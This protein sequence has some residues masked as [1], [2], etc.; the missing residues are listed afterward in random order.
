MKKKIFK[1][2]GIIIILWILVFFL[3]VRLGKLSITDRP[4]TIFGY[5]EI[6]NRFIINDYMTFG[7]DGK[8]GTYL[9]DKGD[10]YEVLTVSKINNKY[11]LKKE[12]IARDS[13]IKLS[14][15][16][17]N[18]DYDIF[19]VNYYS[20]KIFEYSS[21]YKTESNVIAISDIEGNFN[22]FS[23]FLIANKVIDKNFN[24][25]FEDGHLVL[26][27]DF[28]D[29]GLNVTQC[30]WLI[31][32]LECQA[33][34][35]NG[36][37]HFVI[38]NHEA[39]N[40]QG[41]LKYVADKYK[42]LIQKL[43]NKKNFSEGYKKLYNNQFVLGKWLKSKNVV[44]KINKTL[45]VHGGISPEIMNM[46]LGLEEINK[47][48]RENISEN[49]YGK[50]EG[51][52]K[53]NLIMGRIGPLWYRGMAKEYKEYYKK[54]NINE[55][56][57]IL[58]FYEVEQIVIGHTVVDDID[59]DFNKNLIKIDVKHGKE[60]HSGNTKGILI[61]GDSVFKI[62]DKGLK[63]EIKNAVEQ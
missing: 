2:I 14:I 42:G 51:N 50:T 23:S 52:Q 54:M 63:E 34:L 56:D 45:Y 15:E 38:G 19:D 60:K 26:V 49:L 29:R 27:G 44:Q 32:K 25:I 6:E 30:L 61:E 41:N 53:A 58:R 8:D 36:K 39:M 62:N 21:D 48:A 9:L 35:N 16:V 24:W 57:E 31:Y 46:K 3:L 28:M 11:E 5:D 22:A 20:D 1:F 13:I 18:S 40:L 55:F 12:S 7:I 47:I 4:I 10:Q 43:T 17:Q 59:L 37:V 33:E